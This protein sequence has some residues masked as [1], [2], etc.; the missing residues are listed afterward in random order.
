MRAARGAVL[1]AFWML[2][3]VALQAQ[4]AWTVDQLIA[5]AL[6]A[7]PALA[8]ARARIAAAEGRRVQ[9]GLRPNPTV[10]AGLRTEIGGMG[11]MTETAAVL[12]L[13]LFRRGP[14][15]AL[16]DA[17]VDVAEADARRV[18]LAT[19]LDVRRQYGAVL[20]ARRRADVARELE[21]TAK[22]IFDLLAA[23]AEAGAAPPLDRDLARVELERM[24]ARRLAAEADVD[25][26]LV[27]LARA[28]GIRTEPPRVTGAL[29]PAIA[30]PDVAR[31]AGE[32]P[33]TS[34]R[35]HPEVVAAEAR[36]MESAAA[37]DRI[38]SEGK[39]DLSLSAGYVRMRNG[40]PLRAF[41]EAGE[42]RGIQ[43][44]F[45]NVT[46]GAM[47]MVPLFN[48]NQGAVAAG[49][50]EREAAEAAAASTILEAEADVSRTAIEL[51]AALAVAARYRGTI[52]P[53][54]VKNLE[55]VNGRYELGRGTLFDVL[56]AR[57]QLLQIQDEYTDA[58]RRA[59]DAYVEAI[60]ARGGVTR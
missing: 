18:F 30:S 22:S 13:D 36:I 8:E 9:A 59:Y 60:G 7:H 32:A 45:N 37:I 31:L 12:P 42:L 17:G 28:A 2:W 40:F 54:A 38:R 25:A 55:T 46:A 53:Q 20:A 56:Q 19:E 34:V 52:V 16:A 58:L 35:A 1:A 15:I 51:R 26:A 5:R 21:S 43:G 24:T 11:R 27:A 48:R 33:A 50:A 41:D 3:P 4:S 57:Q 29:E 14:R 49:M 10:S 6:E 23:R 44:T 39:W 47:V